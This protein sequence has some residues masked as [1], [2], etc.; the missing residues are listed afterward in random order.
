LHLK[1]ISGLLS[2]SCI[3]VGLTTVAFSQG[4]PGDTHQLPLVKVSQIRALTLEQVRHGYPVHLRG[5]VT[6][7]DSASPDMFVQDDTGAVWVEWLKDRP[8]AVP[9]QWIDL[10]GNARWPSKANG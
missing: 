4:P 7:F 5:V 10:W 9:G 2:L 1:L 3:Y 6:Y 8:V